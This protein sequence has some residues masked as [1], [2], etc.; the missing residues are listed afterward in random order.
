MSSLS[1]GSSESPQIAFP[2]HLPDLYGGGKHPYDRDDSME[3]RLYVIVLS[4][5]WQFYKRNSV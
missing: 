5:T 4:E 2:Y 3:T 1:Q